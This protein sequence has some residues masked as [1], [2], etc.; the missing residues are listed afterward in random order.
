[1]VWVHV[2]RGPFLRGAISFLVCLE[3]RVAWDWYCSN[4]NTNTGNQPSV[5]V[6]F[7]SE[8]SSIKGEGH[9]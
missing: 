5:R 7:M 2:I 9:N 3:R 4:T 6:V 1:M 8:N